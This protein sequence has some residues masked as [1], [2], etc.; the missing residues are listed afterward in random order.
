M[1]LFPDGINYCQKISKNYVTIV[2][3]TKVCRSLGLLGSQEHKRSSDKV[4]LFGSVDADI[5]ENS[6]I[7]HDD[8]V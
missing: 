5:L 7:Y 8:Q 2:S 6:I 1:R 3:C 4:Y